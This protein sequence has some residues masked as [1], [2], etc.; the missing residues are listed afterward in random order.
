VRI[1]EDLQL[2][3][4]Y[5]SAAGVR[6]GIIVDLAA[7]GAG[8]NLSELPAEQRTTVEQMAEHYGVPIKH[9][10]KVARMANTLFTSLH[11]LHELSPQYGRLLEAAAHLHDIGHYVSDNKHHK[12]SYYLVANSDL[13]GFTAREREL[14]A[15]LCRY[16]RRAVPNEM[17]LNWQGLDL[18]GKRA[19]QF[20][21][22]ILRL[23]DNLDRSQDQRVKELNVV[24]RPDEVRLELRGDRDI[25]LEAWAADSASAVFQQI[26]GRPLVVSRSRP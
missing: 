26:Y 19:V 1:L 13:P 17:H 12:H 7:R 9:A 4:L 10:R 18:E 16:H 21:A 15:N 5:H 20:L 25:D 6:D 22:P 8:Y 11:V 24:V 3:A 23:A 2:P 14:I